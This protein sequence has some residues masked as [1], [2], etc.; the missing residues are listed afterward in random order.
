MHT[1]SMGFWKT[2]MREYKWVNDLEFE[3]NYDYELKYLKMQ[4][5]WWFDFIEIS[6]ENL[7]KKNLVEWKLIKSHKIL[8]KKLYE[9]M[10]QAIIQILKWFYW[11]KNNVYMT[12][13][14]TFNNNIWNME[15]HLIVKWWYI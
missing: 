12:K 9:M 6:N 15:T 5:Y 10:K 3:S 1:C 11:K 13:F 2:M 7:K 8:E 14:V 4:T